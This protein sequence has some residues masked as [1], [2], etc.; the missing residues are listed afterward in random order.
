M[1]PFPVGLALIEMIAERPDRQTRGKG[2]V[3]RRSLPRRRPRLSWLLGPSS[4]AAA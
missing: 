2:K 3:E 1:Y 4:R